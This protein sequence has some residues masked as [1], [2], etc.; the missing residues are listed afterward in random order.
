MLAKWWSSKDVPAKIGAILGIALLLY[1]ILIIGGILPLIGYNVLIQ[2]YRGLNLAVFIA[3]TY[4]MFPPK[5]NK[6]RSR[7]VF[8]IDMLLLLMGFIPGMYY[9]LFYDTVLDHLMT[10]SVTLPE[11][12][13]F[14][15]LVISLLEG[16]R[17]TVGLPMVIVVCFFLFHA[18][19]SKIFPGILY[20]RTIP[21]NRL[22]HALYL[23]TGGVFGIPTGVASTTI[24]VFSV[25]AGLLIFSGGGEFFIDFAL[26]ALGIVRGGPAKA[27]IVA[28]AA[29]GT[30]SGSVASNVAATGS[31]TI[32]LMKKTGY[33]TNFSGAVEAVAS[34]GGQLMPPI[35]GAVAFVMAE[36]TGFKYVEICFAALLPA[37]LYYLALFSQ[38]DLEAVRLG[39][40]GIPKDQA[41][42]FWK[43]LK[44]GWQYLVPII[45]LIIF[46]AVLRYTPEKSAM[47]SIVVLILI[48]QIKK[49][50]RL[51]IARIITS[52]DD[53]AKGL[54]TVVLACAMASLIMGSLNSTGVGVRLAM[55]LVRFSGGHLLFLAL[56][57]AVCCFIMGMGLGTITIYL[58]LSVLVAPAMIELGVPRIAAHLFI[59]YWGLVSFITP[60]VC[61]AA[62][63]AASISGGS[64][65][66]TGLIA[67]RLGI[68]TYVVPF[69][70]I[71]NP[72]L[73]MIG[74]PMEIIL[75]VI[76]S[77]I[78]VL[79]L[80][81]GLVGYLYVEKAG[82]ISWIERILL[83]A[84]G[85]A[86]IAPGTLTDIAGIAV[87]ALICL[88]RFIRYREKKR[89]N[90]A[91]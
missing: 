41:P 25:F 27:A 61:I 75:A 1:D 5:K 62:F 36:M 12:I 7:L 13:F 68:V 70:F 86:L 21:F 43:T 42:S 28:S 44:N 47:L 22:V 59:L 82:K 45:A 57:V 71:Y 35:M 56:L 6:K 48:S 79:F 2:P 31:V 32:P 52:L 11:M 80:S 87:A 89:H 15:C 23:D 10:A 51:N 54:C 34:N 9:F 58:T 83:L 81:A 85:V 30:L 33:E 37:I 90:A 73:V 66:K 60:P 19:F 63:V 20:S 4:L 74:E 38:V 69:M 50:S 3:I 77:I 53:T 55:G 65:M 14:G 64:P 8:A 18:F 29:F 76:T 16:G 40:K 78:G 17:R 91:V 39:L 49:D 46:L 84:A 88:F 26:S 67:S 72:V 24:I